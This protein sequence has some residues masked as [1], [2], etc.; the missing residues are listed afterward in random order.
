MHQ[1]GE[2][3]KGLSCPPHSWTVPL[4]TT[5][6]LLLP[7]A[8]FFHTCGG[9]F[10][11]SVLQLT[12]LYG[13]SGSS[14]PQGAFASCPVLGPPGPAHLAPAFTADSGHTHPGVDSVEGPP[15][16]SSVHPSPAS[17]TENGGMNLQVIAFQHRR[18]VTAWRAEVFGSFKFPFPPSQ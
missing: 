5:F 10:P 6:A 4:K 2:T 7:T 16:T 13:T 1:G 8:T 12:P 17:F 9:V 15:L 11:V 14:S 18:L 3:G